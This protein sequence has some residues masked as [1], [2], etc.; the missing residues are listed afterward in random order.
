MPTKFT[1]ASQLFASAHGE[2]CS[3]P[4]AC[5]YCGSPCDGR[6]S[7]RNWLKDTFT[8]WGIV[9]CPHSEFVCAG[10]ALSMREKVQMPGKSKLQKQRN[11]TWL[12]ESHRAVP[13]TKADL[14][15]IRDFCLAPPEPPFAIAI[16]TSG[17][18]HLVF[19]APACHSRETVTLQLEA[20]RVTY[21][22]PG[23]RARLDLCGRIVAA[24]GKPV[25]SERLSPGSV[26][27]IAEYWRD[28][29]YLLNQWNRLGGE[30]LSRLAAFLSA[31]KEDSQRAY[32]S[33]RAA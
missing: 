10:C 5:F 21:R 8:N 33:D 12:I 17:Q 7:T 28:G 6:F 23:L 22:P 11:Y 1:T 9:A 19:R 26:F 27:R 24:L 4:N 25:L 30:P 16:A 13:L 2:S 15:Q 32:P 29:A 31:P 18:Q 20:E 3:G 14:R